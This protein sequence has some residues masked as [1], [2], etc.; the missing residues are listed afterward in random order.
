MWI[1]PKLHVNLWGGGGSLSRSRDTHIISDN[2]AENDYME[3]SQV[4][5]MEDNVAD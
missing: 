1:C 2:E 5:L 4:E 3:V